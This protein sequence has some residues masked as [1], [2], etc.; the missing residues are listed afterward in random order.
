MNSTNN[1]NGQ[2]LHQ[3]N[4]RTVQ[5]QLNVADINEKDSNTKMKVLFDLLISVLTDECDRHPSIEHES[6]ISFLFD[7][8]RKGTLDEIHW[9][10][11][12]EWVKNAAKQGGFVAQFILAICYFEGIGGE[13]NKGLAIEWLKKS[14]EQNYAQAQLCLAYCYF[15][16]IEMEQN[17]GVAIKLLKNAAD[18]DYA[19]AQ[20]CLAFCY[21][22][23]KGVEKSPVTAVEW[24]IKSVD[25]IRLK[26]F[27]FDYLGP[28]TDACLIL[29]EPYRRGNVVDKKNEHSLV[30]NKTVK[31]EV[32]SSYFGKGSKD[33][34]TL[35]AE[36]WLKASSCLVWVYL[37]DIDIDNNFALAMEKK[38]AAEAHAEI[39]DEDW[40]DCQY[41]LALA[42]LA[43]KG[44]EKSCNN[45]VK[46]MVIAAE[47]GHVEATQW[48]ANAYLSLAIPSYLLEKENPEQY[49][50]FVADACLKEVGGHNAAEANLL[51]GVLYLSGKGIEQNDKRALECFEEAQDIYDNTHP[52]PDNNEGL[53]DFIDLYL[54][55]FY[56]QGKS[57]TRS[58]SIEFHAYWH[59]KRPH[60]YWLGDLS[61]AFVEGFMAMQFPYHKCNKV[62]LTLLHITLYKKAGEY[63]L[64]NEFTKDVFDNT[65]GMD[66]NFKE[67]CLVGIEQE[68]EIAKKNQELEARNKLL[69]E[70]NNRMQKLVEQFTHTLGNVIFPD[71][72]YQVAER[73]EKQFLNAVK[74]S[75]CCTKP[76][77]RK[78]S[79]NCK[80]NYCVNAM[81]TP[82]LKNFASLLGVAAGL[83]AVATKP[84]R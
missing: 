43:G 80:A 21:L 10:L 44:V 13:K 15:E 30:W 6:G 47:H 77:I 42:Y 23:G 49:Y 60:D 74:M 9:V 1:S 71:T 38:L 31:Y 58:D 62:F 65:W 78:S 17:A 75:Y 61:K 52:D 18:Q 64:A 28:A 79:S 12:F 83:Q 54:S 34:S 55:V 59:S 7:C 37:K 36:T 50:K 25:N 14:T 11:V 35:F 66:K 5:M 29:S 56:S 84:N 41:Q 48:I 40:S 82:T 16:G 8:Y 67:V 2:L 72:I 20:L 39:F 53:G 63:E 3:D 24:L 46:W 70:A 19:Y 68:Q 26:S 73:L 76:I 32:F 33:L 69:Q 45:C 27:S 22:D 81:P 51:L 57:T 4:N